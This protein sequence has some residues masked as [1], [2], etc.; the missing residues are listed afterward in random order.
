MTIITC[1]HCG[2]TRVAPHDVRCPNYEGE[3]YPQHFDYGQ[4][5]T[6]PVHKGEDFAQIGYAS[7]GTSGGDYLH[8]QPLKQ[9]WAEEGGIIG[10]VGTEGRAAPVYR[11]QITK[12]TLDLRRKTLTVEVAAEPVVSKAAHQTVPNPY[13]KLPECV[14][15][16]RPVQDHP[17]ASPGQLFAYVGQHIR[18][19]RP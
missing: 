11:D 4:D 12:T 9:P 5:G 17:D 1:D 3:R 8:Y 10:W 13:S 16:Y 6:P 19:N 7:H 2:P 14:C 15:G 18:E